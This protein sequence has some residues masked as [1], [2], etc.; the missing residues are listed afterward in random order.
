MALQRDGDG[1]MLEHHHIV[2][3]HQH[4]NQPRT[5]G[6]QQQDFRKNYLRP[7]SRPSS[8][9]QGKPEGFDSDGV[10]FTVDNGGVARASHPAAPPGTPAQEQ[11]QQ[12]QQHQQQHQQQRQLRSIGGWLVGW[13]SVG[14]SVG[15]FMVLLKSVSA[16]ARQT[17]TFTLQASQYVAVV[18]Q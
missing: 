11:Q 9:H 17:Q 7:T 6:R 8:T 16:S 1:V 10:R 13:L 4:R 3:P 12:H 14:R 5:P 15:R 2:A 18:V